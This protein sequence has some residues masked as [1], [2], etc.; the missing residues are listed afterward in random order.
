MKMKINAFENIKLNRKKS[1]YDDIL[2]EVTD[3]DG[4]IAYGSDNVAVANAL[5]VTKQMVT[6]ALN[7]PTKF[8]T[9]RGCKL[10]RVN[11]VTLEP[12]EG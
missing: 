12:V 4:N 5:G 9:V 1:H 3:K 10:R 7:N 8:H 11:S 6:N 2:I